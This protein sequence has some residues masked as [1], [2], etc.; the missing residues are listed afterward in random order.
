MPSTRKAITSFGENAKKYIRNN[1]IGLPARG[2]WRFGCSVGT[3]AE[4]CRCYSR[5][6][7]VAVA[8][9]FIIT[10]SGNCIQRRKTA[11]R[12]AHWIMFRAR[13]IGEI[14]AAIKSTF[15]IDEQDR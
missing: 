3:G 9:M 5:R 15:Y 11:G 13:T 7:I 8:V 1:N 6:T 2:N 10:S 12:F 14:N 4:N